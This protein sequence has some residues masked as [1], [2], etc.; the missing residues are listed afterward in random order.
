MSNKSALIA[1]LHKSGKTAA[2]MLKILKLLGSRSGMYEMINMFK[3]TGSHLPNIKSFPTRSVRTKKLVI[4]MRSKLRSISHIDNG[5]RGK[6]ES[7][8]YSKCL[9]IIS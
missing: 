2:Q 3:S 4:V 5:E 8:D 1:N 9:Q 7:Y 6:C